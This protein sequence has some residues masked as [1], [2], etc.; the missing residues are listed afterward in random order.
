MALISQSSSSFIPK[1]ALE[2]PKTGTSQ[3]IGLI[4]V[5]SIMIFLLSAIVFG[6]ALL[7]KSLLNN[8]INT[9][10]G[11][12]ED[13]EQRCGLKATVERERRNID[14]VTIESLERLDRKLSAVGKLVEQHKDLL[15]VFKLL[16]KNTLPSVTYTN[17]NYSAK[18]IILDGR[19]LG[20]ED[21]AVQ[22]E[23]FTEAKRNNQLQEFMFSDLDQDLDGRVKFKLTLVLNPSVVLAATP[24]AQ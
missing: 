22:S 3:P 10:C 18:N 23:V 21:I 4:L 9:P 8:E 17:F 12:T 24:L 7:Y 11:S 6:G 19:A 15:R 14:Q 2:R 16:E 1:S 5:V 13:G 20:F